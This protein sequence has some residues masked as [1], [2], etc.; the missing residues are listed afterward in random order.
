MLCQCKF[1]DCKKC[2]TLVEMVM[3]AEAQCTWGQGVYGESLY[4]QFSSA[5]NPK[6]L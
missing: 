1:S 4:L 2:I 5:V 3:V 6:L